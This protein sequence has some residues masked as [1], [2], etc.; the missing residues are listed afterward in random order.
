M[1]GR[2]CSERARPARTLYDQYFV[3]TEKS[4]NGGS[5]RT[6]SCSNDA[7]AL[8]SPPTLPRTVL[9]KPS[10]ARAFLSAREAPSVVD[11]TGGSLVR[12]SGIDPPEARRRPATGARAPRRLAPRREAAAADDIATTHGRWASRRGTADAPPAGPA[13]GLAGAQTNL[14]LSE[15][16]GGVGFSRRRGSWGASPDQAAIAI[17]TPPIREVGRGAA[18]RGGLRIHPE[19]TTAS[20]RASPT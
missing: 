19:S 10:R 8:V 17:A 3:A 20:Q 4:R 9:R 7:A 18:A 16:E 6:G 14:Y 2:S 12:H 15:E 11:S 13:G 5:G 1:A